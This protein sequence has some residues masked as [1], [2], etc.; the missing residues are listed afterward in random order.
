MKMQSHSESNIKCI[1]HHQSQK[2]LL[3][4]VFWYFG[5]FSRE[6]T[7]KISKPIQKTRYAHL[8]YDK[9]KHK[10]TVVDEKGIDTQWG[11]L[12]GKHCVVI[13]NDFGV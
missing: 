12:I 2:T 11:D 7:H 6:F 13:L 9:E 3:D 5:K 1:E 4:Q 8:N 10:I